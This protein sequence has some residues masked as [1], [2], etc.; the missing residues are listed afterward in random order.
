MAIQGFPQGFPQISA[1]FCDPDTGQINQTWLQLL[2]SLFG[3]TGGNAGN[4]PGPIQPLTVS[5]SP[6]SYTASTP[7]HIWI[8]QGTYADV[9]I[10]RAA[11][12]VSSGKITRGIFP[13]SPNDL[14]TITFTDLP[15]TIYFI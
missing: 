15:P 13:M 4:L 7:G 3:R 14:I 11:L 5:G 9:T 2:I 12:T 1:P 10:T 6:F 8:D